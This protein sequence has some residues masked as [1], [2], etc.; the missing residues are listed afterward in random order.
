[1]GYAICPA[2]SMD[3]HRAGTQLSVKPAACQCTTRGNAAMQLSPHAL[4]SCPAPAHGVARVLLEPLSYG[5]G[6]NFDALL[7]AGPSNRSCSIE[8]WL[9]EV[10]CAAARREHPLNMGPSILWPSSV[11]FLN[12]F[13]CIYLPT[14]VF[15]GIGPLYT[16]GWMPAGA[17]GVGC[18]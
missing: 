16:A 3:V 18:H 10:L 8:K 17:T 15:T 11:P 14:L 13:V 2:W 1:M 7:P 6:I 12:P 9:K 4:P 5:Q